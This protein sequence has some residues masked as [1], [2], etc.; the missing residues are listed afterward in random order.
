MTLSRSRLFLLATAV[1]FC[2]PTLGLAG[3]RQSLSLDGTW[4]IV[5]DPDNVGREGGWQQGNVFSSRN[6]RRGIEV[7]SCWEEIEE[8]YEGVAFYLR[9]FQVPAS[10]AGKAIRLQFDAVN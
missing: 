2:F 3:S 4:E 1:A 10:W 8:D 6:D 7:P 9:T 5:F